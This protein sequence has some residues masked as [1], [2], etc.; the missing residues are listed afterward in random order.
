[1]RVDTIATELLQA[2]TVLRFLCYYNMEM[3]VTWTIM[4]N[5]RLNGS[6]RTTW[7]SSFVLAWMALLPGAASLHAQPAHPLD[8]LTESEYAVVIQA[9]KAADHVDDRSRYPLIALQPPDKGGVYRWSPGETFTRKAFAIVKN[10]GDT[11]E[12]VIDI[13]SATVESWRRVDGVQPSILLTEDWQKA[14]AYVRSNPEWQAAI[15]K[16]GVDPG[17]VVCIPNTVGFFGDD[18]GGR[19]LVKVMSYDSGGIENFWGRPIEGLI[20]VVDLDE[21]AVVE[22]IDQG[23][24][25][26]PNAPSDFDEESVGKLRKP[27]NAISIDQPDGASFDVNGHVVRWQKWQFHFRMDPRLGLV[28]SKVSYEDDGRERPILYEGSLSELFVPYMD[29]DMGWYFRTFMDAGEY[30]IGKLAVELSPGLD[31][32]ETTVLFPAVFAD[33]WGETY[34]EERV[35]GLFERYAGDIAWR[36]TEAVTGQTEVR[37]RTE[38]VLRFITAIGNYDYIFDWVFRQNGSI[39]VRV[40]ASGGAL[41][42]AVPSS[43]LSDSDSATDT[44]FGHLIAEHT[45]AI[46]HDHF[47]CYRLDL[48]VDGPNNSFLHERLKTRSVERRGSPRKSVW[49]IDS[50]TAATEGEAKFRID[51]TKPTLWRVINPNVEGSLG[52]PVSY[53]LKAGANAVT[54]LNPDDYPQRRAGFTDY[55]L[56]VTPHDPHELYAAGTYPNQSQGGDGLPKW[57]SAHRGI[58]NTDIVLWYTVGFHHVVRAEDWPVLPVSWHEFELRPFDFFDRNPAIDIPR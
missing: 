20:V 16:R 19:R 30:G 54:L 53:H 10:G 49:A 31:C 23:V 17:A 38:L 22:I 51:L 52:Y 44:E 3:F 37:R 56:W 46:N 1:M 39:K 29:P 14:Q 11:F 12:T 15:R 28:V 27:P 42:K 9:L 35:I 47:F 21:R 4:Y 26:V 57:T 25:P 5:L 2:W 43:K 24:R 8:P 41:V 36:H 48:D 40:G 6:L 45:V 7:L 55:H 13:D 50:N 32:P 34:V 33:D 18:H 58:V